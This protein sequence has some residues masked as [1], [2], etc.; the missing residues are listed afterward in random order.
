M[1]KHNKTISE[2]NNKLPSFKNNN[3]YYNHD[4]VIKNLITLKKKQGIIL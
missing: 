3:Y 4:L 1:W 2:Q